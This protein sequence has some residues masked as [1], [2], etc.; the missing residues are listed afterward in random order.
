VDETY[1]KLAVNLA[2]LSRAVDS[3]SDTI[4]F[5]L[6]P[7]RNLTAARLFLRS[8]SAGS[9]GKRGIKVDGH[10]ARAR[11]IAEVKQTHELGRHC[12]CRPSPII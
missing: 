8:A 11:A 9:H 2:Y 5:T 10:P 6:S 4:D 1:V 3:V 12:R 7:R